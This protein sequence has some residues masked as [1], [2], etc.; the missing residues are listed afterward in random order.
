MER[1]IHH[2]LAIYR[3]QAIIEPLFS[4]LHI[5]I[6]ISAGPN[7]GPIA[8]PS[9]CLFIEFVVKN[10]RMILWWPW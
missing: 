5:K 6:L 7:G 3:R 8:T 10:K 1:G 9:I 4:K 2:Q